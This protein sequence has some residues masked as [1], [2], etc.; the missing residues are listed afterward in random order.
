MT[1]HFVAVTFTC[2]FKA[3]YQEFTTYILI[4]KNNF[5]LSGIHLASRAK[6]TSA[7]SSPRQCILNDYTETGRCPKLFGILVRVLDLQVT[8]TAENEIHA[9]L[10]TNL[11]NRVY[12]HCV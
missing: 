7:K 6:E 9:R 8:L 12:N 10:Q 1:V 4:Y 3:K 5:S 2:G 11:K